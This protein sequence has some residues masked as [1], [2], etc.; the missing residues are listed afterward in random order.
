MTR[1]LMTAGWLMAALCPLLGGCTVD[2]YARMILEQNTT[3]GRNLQK[4]A[5]TSDQLVK[6]GKISW[7]R[8]FTMPDGVEID[9][10]GL[11]AQ[12]ADAHGTVLILHGLC[13]SKV[14]YLPMAQ[15]LSQKGFD[16]ILPDFRAHGRSTGKYVTYGALESRDTQRVMAALLDEK[17][18]A[19]PLYVFGASMNLGGSVAIIYAAAE[20]RVKGLIAVAPSRSIQA[21]AGRFQYTKLLDDATL[22]RIVRRAGKIGGFDPDDAS[23]IRAIPN[24]RCPVLLI[25]GKL[26]LF[27]PCSDSQ[28][29]YDAAHQPKE[30]QIIPWAG[31]LG[32]VVGREAEMVKEIERVAAGKLISTSM[33]AEKE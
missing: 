18:V 14:T 16:V 15:T 13:D 19:G 29:L 24:V 6:A 26:D 7:A 11:R 9:V 28:A 31:H 30:L 4:M 2:Q 32:T 33:P 1:R 20:P 23:A 25:H 5:G 17:A 22:D 12:G 10:W 8:R 3:W 27:T 21:T